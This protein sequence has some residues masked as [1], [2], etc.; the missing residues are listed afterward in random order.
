MLCGRKR[1]GSLLAWHSLA[2]VLSSSA[3]SPELARFPQQ[4]KGLEGR[5]D[6]I[7]CH[8]SA[9]KGFA[10]YQEAVV[11]GLGEPNGLF[12][13]GVTGKF[14]NLS[15]RSLLIC[16][17]GD[18]N[19]IY[20]KGLEGLIELIDGKQLEKFLAQTYHCVYYNYCVSLI[21]INTII[22]IL[23]SCSLLVILIK[24]IFPNSLHFQWCFSAPYK[25]VS[26]H[27]PSWP[28]PKSS[29]AWEPQVQ[30]TGFSGTHARA[31]MCVCV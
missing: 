17:M 8:L 18:N 24:T 15:G 1:Q 30:W 27:Q 11:K 13:S 31:C 25:L 26:W 22:I 20:S 3:P 12:T 29:L 7:S 9:P 16:I 6:T 14:L 21:I 4:L 2:I 5:L 28:A 10:P 19:N 23:M